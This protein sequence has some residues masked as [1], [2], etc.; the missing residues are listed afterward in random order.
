MI[1]QP[2]NEQQQ[3]ID[4]VGNA[5]VTAKP[6]SGKTFTIVEKIAQILPD[7][8][9]YKGVVAISFTNKA[10]DELKRRCKQRCSDTKQ[11]FFG[12]IDKFYISQIIIPFACH[13]TGRQFEYKIVNEI[14]EG[15]KYSVFNSKGTIT[16]DNQTELLIEGLSE[17]IIF[18]KYTGETALI[19]LNSVSGALRYLKAKYSHIFIDEYQDCGWPQHEVFTCLVNSGLVGIAVGDMDQAI[20]GFTG[21]FPEYLISLI[22]DKKYSHFQINKNNRS[23]PSIS[24]YSLCLLGAPRVI[25]TEKRVFKVTVE[26]NECNIAAKID[27]YLE[28]IKKKYAIKNNNEVAILCRS[29]RSAS[30]ISGFLSTPHKLYEDSVLDKDNSEWGRLFRE[31]LIS[32]FDNLVYALDFT[33]DLFSERYEPTK[34]RKALSL[35]T[36]IFSCSPD[37]LGAIEKDIISLAELVYPRNPNETAVRE[38]HSILFDEEKLR[39]FIPAAE[40]ELNVMTLHKSKGLEFG[41]VFHLDLYKWILPNEHGT[42]QE[43]QQDL[44][45]HYVGITRAKEACYL[46]IGTQR[47][48]SKQMDYIQSVPSPFLDNPGLNE[49]R[50][51]V[52]WE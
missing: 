3:I 38:L 10:S 20:Y 1:N 16:P 50:R 11:S 31:I 42:A 19:V 49:R 39:S 27:K 29:N 9:D 47:F 17:G 36:N 43:K 30:Q 21:R 7:L 35:C 23:H 52:V 28:S 13:I 26:G 5:V 24:E 51:N 8:P 2:T 14:P 33:A 32:Y 6:G 46:M 18:L 48:R 25:P 40:N 41:I 4:C 44:N 22:R 34:Y 12:T 37:N 45:L 15:S